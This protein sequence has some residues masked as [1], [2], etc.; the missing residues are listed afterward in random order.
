[1]YFCLI[2]I[3]FLTKDLRMTRIT[4]DEELRSRC[5]SLR[6]EC[7][8]AE[9]VV[10]KSSPELLKEIE[11]AISIL[12]RNLEIEDISKRGPVSASRNAYRACGKDPARYRLSAEAL[13]RRICSGKELYQIN[14]VVDQL[15]LVSF[16]SGFSIGGYDVDQLQGEISF[17]IGQ[18]G[19]PYSGIG[20]GELNIEHLPVFRDQLGAFG[21]PTSDSHRTEVTNSTRNFLM[22]LIDF[23][24]SDE[25]LSASKRACDLLER[26]CSAK[27]ITTF[28]IE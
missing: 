28:H 5:P 17:G 18:S 9:V 1:L 27:N 26:Y 21:T 22:I 8:E 14:N 25:L 6:L 16:T 4:I 24:H 3:G 13:M 10:E 11:T 12:S 20:R 2:T 7:I 19:E 15:N 23:G